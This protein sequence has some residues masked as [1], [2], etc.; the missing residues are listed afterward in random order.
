MTT[1]FAAIGCVLL[2]V[3]AQFLIKAGMSSVAVKAALAKPAALHVAGAV[4]LNPAII[5]GFALYTL[6]AVVWL[7]VLARWDV[8]KAYPLEGLGF[9]LALLVGFLIGEQVTLLR[10]LG[11][12]L[13]CAGVFVISAS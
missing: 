3:T 8:S 5:G 11:V 10:T 1:T 13:I 12:L 2:S 6:G 7:W 9:A 4:M